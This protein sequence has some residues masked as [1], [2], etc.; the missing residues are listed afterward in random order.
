[1]KKLLFPYLFLLLAFSACKTPCDLCVDPPQ[2]PILSNAV[3]ILNE[4]AYTW[5][6]ASLSCYW[7][8]SQKVSNGVYASV[9]TIPLGD[10]A[11]SVHFLAGYA[12]LVVNN[13]GRVEVLNLLTAKSSGATT[14]LGSPR[15]FHPG[16]TGE[17][18]VTDLYAN[19]ISKIELGRFSIVEEESLPVNGWTEEMLQIGNDL[20]VCNTD[21]RQ[22]YILDLNS[23]TLDSMDV[24]RAP[25]SLVE[26]KN[27]KLWVLSDGGLSEEKARLDRVD[28]LSRSVELSLEFP[29]LSSS[30]SELKIN[31]AGDRV[32]WLNGG[33]WSLE[34]EENTLPG[35][36]MIPSNGR[37]L[38]SLGI[39]PVSGDIYT[40]D[41]KDFVQKGQ[42]YRYNS[43]GTEISSF[44]VGVGPGFV[45]FP[46]Q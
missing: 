3:W 5:G 43:Q 34:V 30:P 23:E 46:P 42:M 18:W 13:S 4:G 35:A 7:P 21:G 24:G 36:A 12:F 31:A 45:A 14:G 2:L 40:G 26:D 22:L 15:F 16:K 25:V 38:Y 1:M 19:N 10:V 11:Q 27:G 8:D 41:A 37:N 9:N 17:A 29:D 33:V 44:A 39:H 28:P 6:N 32:Y 20:F